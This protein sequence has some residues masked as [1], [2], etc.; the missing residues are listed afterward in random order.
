LIITD[1]GASTRKRGRRAEQ[2]R[3]LRTEV[4]ITRALE[5]AVSDDEDLLS[6]AGSLEDLSRWIGEEFRTGKSEIDW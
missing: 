4:D 6:R 2:L 3:P 1:A 5:T